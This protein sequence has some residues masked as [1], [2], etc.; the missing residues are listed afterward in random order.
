MEDNQSSYIK[1]YDKII[2]YFVIYTIVFITFVKTLPYTIPFVLAL[3]IASII[4]PIIK[5]LAKWTKQKIGNN[6]LILFSMLI[7]YGIIGTLVTFFII[8]VFDQST[9]L[10]TNAIEYINTNYESIAKWVQ[11]QYEWLISNIQN[12]DPS[13]IESG[14]T[15]LGTML[16]SLQNIL[17]SIGS[18]IGGFALTLISQVPTFFLI[19][20]FTVVCSFFFTKMFLKTPDVMYKY[21][22]T[23]KSDDKRL[24]YI[25]GEGKNMVIR[26]G[27]SYL[28]V[29]LIT[30]AISTVGYM[31]MG[32]PYALILGVITAFLDLMPVLG[33]SAAYV[34]LAI[35]YLAIGN[36]TIPVGLGILYIIVAV[37][38]NIWEPRIVASSLDMNPIITIMAIFIGLK[39]NG[40]VGMFYLMF[41]AVGYK[42]LQK[43]KVLDTF[44]DPAPPTH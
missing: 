7:F 9:L 4:T 17:V 3:I 8:K 15:M 16:N 13:I 32:I 24:K 30:G 23:S 36:Y 40:I 26:Y 10:I 21:L 18:A 12:L 31:I 35:Y 19:V 14:R 6:L 28:L 11:A 37:G 5:L 20:I 42:V 44:E 33:V 29:I 1:K 43:V 38:R 39:L 2:I 22:P 34:P 25:I 27:L 41:M